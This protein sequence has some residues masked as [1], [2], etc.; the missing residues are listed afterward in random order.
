MY[1]ESMTGDCV[2]ISYLHVDF[3]AEFIP[4]SPEFR[5]RQLGSHSIFHCAAPPP[6][7][8][9]KSSVRR[10][11]VFSV[12]LARHYIYPILLI[13]DRSILPSSPSLPRPALHSPPP[14]RARLSHP[15]LSSP[16]ML[17]VSQANALVYSTL[18]GF[19]L[20][21]LYAGYNVRSKFD[22]ISGIRTQSGECRLRAPERLNAD[23]KIRLQSSRSRSIGSRQVSTPSFYIHTSPKSRSDRSIHPL[24]SAK[25]QNSLQIQAL[26]DKKVLTAA[27]VPLT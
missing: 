10:I 25:Q 19:M 9:W 16:T 22:F 4:K 8:R 5:P 17:D 15:H 3:C 7:G 26:D 11:L 27:Q 20:V 14:S 18:A 13:R 2:R 21:G 12:C 24:T 6:P 1:D 23:E